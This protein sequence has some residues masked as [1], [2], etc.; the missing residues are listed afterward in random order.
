[1]FGLLMGRVPSSVNN[2]GIS[3]SAASLGWVMTGCSS[4][5]SLPREK[6]E[7]NLGLKMS[8]KHL[9]TEHRDQLKLKMYL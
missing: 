9:G 1:M 7:I 6:S 5:E 4:E 3:V 8:A 2:T